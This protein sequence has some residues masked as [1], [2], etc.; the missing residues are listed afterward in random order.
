MP[1]LRRDA[2]ALLSPHL[3]YVRLGTLLLFIP[4]RR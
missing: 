4:P 3:C 1:K 2:G